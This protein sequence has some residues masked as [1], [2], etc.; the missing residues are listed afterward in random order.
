[1]AQ[2]KASGKVPAVSII[3]SGADSICFPTW[4]HRITKWPGLKRTTMIIEFQPPCYVQGRQPPHQAAQSHIQPGLECFQ[5]WGSTASLGN[6]FQCV[7]TL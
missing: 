2:E 6:L 5:G 4:N 7:T 3:H 1:M